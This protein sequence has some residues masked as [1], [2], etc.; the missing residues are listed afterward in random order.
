AAHPSAAKPRLPARSSLS[1]TPL[2]G[3][4]A[5]TGV[6]LV[7]PLRHEERRTRTQQTCAGTSGHRPPGA[8]RTARTSSWLNDQRQ[9]C[10]RAFGVR[11]TQGEGRTSY[12]PKS[13]PP[14]VRRN[15]AALR[16]QPIRTSEGG[17]RQGG[18]TRTS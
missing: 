14:N 16:Q 18:S 1:I 8:R 12:W 11:S 17:H 6:V 7:V 10:E 5:R 15:T 13:G 2:I 9:R 3:T 4:G